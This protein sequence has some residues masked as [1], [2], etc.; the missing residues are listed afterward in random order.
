MDIKEIQKLQCQRPVDDFDFF[1]KKLQKKLN[2]SDKALIY[3]L[4]S[5]HEQNEYL[6]K[7][8]IYKMFCH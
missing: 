1:G 2:T 3:E 8:A 6:Q 4:I 7:I 5:I